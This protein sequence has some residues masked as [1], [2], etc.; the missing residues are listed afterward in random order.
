MRG[1]LVWGGAV[2]G[3]AAMSSGSVVY[4][5][6]SSPQ[7][8]A[9]GSIDWWDD[10]TIVGGGQ[11]SGFAF[12]ANNAQAG[13]PRPLTTVISIYTFNAA[14]N[15][16]N[17]TLL[18]SFAITSAPIPAGGTLFVSRDDLAL[19]T[20]IVLPSNGRLGVKFDFESNGGAIMQS[21]PTIGSSANAL[22]TDAPP[23]PGGLPNFE[24]N[25][26]FSL[27]VVPAPGAAVS[28]AAFGLA[29]LRRRAR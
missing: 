10:A 7:V 13:A 8:Q 22:W 23:V 9:V 2:C 28:L 5:N 27:T 26:G 29:G 1:I 21:T 17:G 4:S 6:L 24:N 18:G 14:T 16:P 11:L 20:N 25:I 15:L 12:Y 19:S 3:C